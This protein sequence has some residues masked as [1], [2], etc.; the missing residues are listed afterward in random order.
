MTD[1]E[2]HLILFSHFLQIMVFSIYIIYALYSNE[3]IKLEIKKIR[4]DTVYLGSV[5]M[6]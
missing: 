4:L 2:K 5:K 3:S 1:L 6:H